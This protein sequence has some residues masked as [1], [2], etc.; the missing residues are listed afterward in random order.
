MV[1]TDKFSTRLRITRRAKTAP[2]ARTLEHLPMTFNRVDSIRAAGKC[3]DS[4]SAKSAASNM[5]ERVSHCQFTES[6]RL[7]D[8]V[9]Q[10]TKTASSRPATEGGHL[11]QPPVPALRLPSRC[12]DDVRADCGISV[13]DTAYSSCSFRTTA[14]SAKHTGPTAYGSPIYNNARNA[15]SAAYERIDFKSLLSDRPPN[16][17]RAT[18]DIERRLKQSNERYRVTRQR[19]QDDERDADATCRRGDIINDGDF[20]RFILVPN[21]HSTGSRPTSSS[22]RALA[23]VSQ[24]LREDQFGKLD[25]ESVQLDIPGINICEA[26]SE[27]K[28]VQDSHADFDH[29]L[30]TKAAANVSKHASQSDVSKAGLRVNNKKVKLQSQV[31]VK[32]SRKSSNHSKASPR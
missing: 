1:C 8:D 24:M 32:S 6:R 9:I 19:S 5:A 12:F 16:Y 27:G 20:S 29:R 4:M 3:R 25:V 23:P 30:L 14:T 28:D 26:E 18:P 22:K 2:V 17:F 11:P 21:K 31:S 13:R 15:H 10:L 7:F